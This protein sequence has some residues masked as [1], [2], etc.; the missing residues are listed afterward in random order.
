MTLGLDEAGGWFPIQECLAGSLRKDLKSFGGCSVSQSTDT[1]AVWMALVIL[2]ILLLTVTDLT[3]REL[4]F[5]H[6]VHD[7][8]CA[9]PVF[10]A[11][12]A[13]GPGVMVVKETRGAPALRSRPR[14]Q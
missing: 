11:E 5:L 9:W 4:S 12:P 2:T 13:P 1:C 10:K 3:E 6:S 8:L 7:S 14:K